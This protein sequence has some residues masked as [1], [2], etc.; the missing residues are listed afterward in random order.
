MKSFIF[1]LM[2]LVMFGCASLQ[3]PVD[4]ALLG[5]M[6]QPEKVKISS[7]KDSIIVKK[8]EKDVSEKTVEVSEQGIL[9]SKSRAQLL[10]SQKDY[11]IKREKYY[12]LS[13]DAAKLQEARTMTKRTEDL[14]RQESANTEYCTAK[15]DFDLAAFKV[16]EGE[17]SV[18]VSQLDFEKAKIAR[19]YQV[20]RYGEKYNKLIDTKITMLCRMI[21][22]AEKKI[23]RRPRMP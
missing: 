18:L 1:V 3:E 14:S 22:T 11:Y 9:V 4:E 19:E 8:N 23:I 2:S 6:T 12:L 21:S 13:N 7:I 10:V 20:R 15:R 16:K 17:M 5:E